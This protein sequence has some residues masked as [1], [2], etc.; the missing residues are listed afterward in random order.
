MGKF[1]ARQR[2]IVAALRT[3]REEAGLSQRAL[4]AKL[5]ESTTYIHMIEGLRRDVSVAEFMEIAKAVGVAPDE[6][7]RR[8]MR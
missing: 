6:L 8:V 2:A 4:S 7:M 5:R 3:A 1:P